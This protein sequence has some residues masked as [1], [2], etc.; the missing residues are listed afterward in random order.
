MSS[1]GGRAAELPD[2]RVRGGDPAHPGRSAGPASAVQAWRA[3]GSRNGVAAARQTHDAPERAERPGQVGG[4]WLRALRRALVVT[5]RE[6]RETM[7]DW[8][9]LVPML[10]LA[11][12]FPLLLVTGMEVGLPYMDRVDPQAAQEKAALFGAMMAA[13]FPISFSLVIALESFVGEKERN[14]LEALLSTPISDGELFMGKLLAVLVPPVGLSVVAL[15]VYTAALALVL[16]TLVPVDFLGLIVALSVVESLAMVTSAVVISSHTT[17]VRAANLLA[18]FIIIPVALTVQ[19]QVMLLLMGYGHA[20][21]FFLAA[22]ML[23]AAMLTRMGVA[24]FNREEILTREGDDLNPRVVVATLLRFWH[25]L[26]AEALG[27][28]RAES[29]APARLSLRRLYLV[30]IPQLLRTS[31]VSI[32][33]VTAVM[34]AAAVMGYAYAQMYP[35]ALEQDQLGT[36]IQQAGVLERLSE[37][38]FS[39]IFFHNVKVLA[40][41]ALLSIFSFGVAGLVIL[42]SAFLLLGFLAGEA[43][44]AGMSPVLFL[45][46]FVV[47]HGMVEVPSVILA[48]AFSLKIGLSLM[49]PPPGFTIGD[50]LMLSLVNW[51]KGAA[52]FL[53]LLLLAAWIE[54]TITPL[55]ALHFLGW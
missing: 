36:A 30:D 2:G 47:P 7:S 32:L 38:S 49:A 28:P 40:L 50:S 10:G 43:A 42:L 22:F 20:L 18:S 37:L 53:P 16:E 4:A 9:V 46:A 19:A 41:S 44:H 15:G 17:S 23:V 1:D 51:V 6:V 39:T 11:L 26:P 25:R 3:E 5:R 8:R 48:G 33:V 35:L 52:L 55:V 29:S 21:W 12:L 34:I 54:T 45:G 13:F 14:T 27:H 31:R 24:V